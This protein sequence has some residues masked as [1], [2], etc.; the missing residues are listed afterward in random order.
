MKLFWIFAALFL[1]FAPARAH[2]LCLLGCSCTVA[3]DPVS[4]GSID[5]IANQPTNAVGA[6]NVSCAGTLNLFVNNDIALSR[7]GAPSFSPRRMQSGANTLNYNLYTDSART[8]IWG[9]GS[10]STSIASKSFNL[11]VFGYSYSLPVYARVPAT[12]TAVPAT[13]YSDTITVTITF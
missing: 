7:G 9:D 11:G 13:L 12:P 5:P 2:A 6:V 10:G 1:V 8:Q 3:A 4:F